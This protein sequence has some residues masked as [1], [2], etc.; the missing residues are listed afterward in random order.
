MLRFN[1]QPNCIKRCTQFS[2]HKLASRLRMARMMLTPTTQLCLVK[3]QFC[4]STSCQRS[5]KA[6]KP[7]PLPALCR[8]SAIALTISHGLIICCLF[9]CLLFYISNATCNFDVVPSPE[10]VLEC[11]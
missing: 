4:G 5:S 7:P 8:T 2:W 3:T 9:I 6:T 11:C 1:K 10:K